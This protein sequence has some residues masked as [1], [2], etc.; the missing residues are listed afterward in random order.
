[1][2]VLVWFGFINFI[3]KP[4]ITLFPSE[5]K[6]KE[7]SN[8]LF[9]SD[10]FE[11]DLLFSLLPSLLSP[12]FSSASSSLLL[13]FSSSRERKAKTNVKQVSTALVAKLWK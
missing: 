10:W 8:F 7:N 5:R 9:K 11:S 6:P 2:V 13:L 3:K 1:M 4:I 12:L